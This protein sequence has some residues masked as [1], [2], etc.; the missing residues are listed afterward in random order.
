[1]RVYNNVLSP[2]IKSPPSPINQ[3]GAMRGSADH[4]STIIPR[5]ST[6]EARTAAQA[7]EIE[8]LRQNGDVVDVWRDRVDSASAQTAFALEALNQDVD[9]LRCVCV[10]V[11]VKHMCLFF[12]CILVLMCSLILLS[13]AEYGC[14]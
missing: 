6:L 7:T 4:G 14:K 10:C 2:V 5:L 12:W 3:D 8:L 13:C 1:M 11:C 9:Q